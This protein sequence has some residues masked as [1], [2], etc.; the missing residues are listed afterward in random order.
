MLDG[1]L[2]DGSVTVGSV[3]HLLHGTQRLPMRVKGVV[4]GA[5]N[6]PHYDLSL[7]IDLRE[8]AMA[9]ACVGDRLVGR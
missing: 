6:S 5:A 3:V 1:K 7:T 2:L 9:V 4:I 8:A